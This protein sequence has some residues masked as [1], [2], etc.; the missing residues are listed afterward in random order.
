MPIDPQEFGRLQADVD[1]LSSAVDE[2][3]KDVKE[4][5]AVVENARG[6]WKTLVAIGGV[7][8]A[9]GSIATKLLLWLHGS[10]P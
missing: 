2:L 3:R 10:A 4:L 9:V 7:S 8:A 6:G 5:L 1:H